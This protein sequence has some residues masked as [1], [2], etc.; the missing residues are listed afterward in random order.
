M[1]EPPGDSHSHVWVVRREVLH[2]QFVRDGRSPERIEI[3]VAWPPA[4]GPLTEYSSKYSSR[5]PHHFSGK[6][7]VHLY[8]GWRHRKQRLLH[9]YRVDSYLNS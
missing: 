5:V 6:G 8:G 1:C 4:V 2:I 7:K 3:D 9:M